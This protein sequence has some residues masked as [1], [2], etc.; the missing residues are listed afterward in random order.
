MKKNFLFLLIIIPFFSFGQ[1]YQGDSWAKV[2][3]A[4]SG[5][6]GIVYNE[7]FGLIFK[8]PNGNVSGVCVDI[9]SD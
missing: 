9:I 3:S 8:S 7:Q 1:K 6:L 4:G 5:T 2:K